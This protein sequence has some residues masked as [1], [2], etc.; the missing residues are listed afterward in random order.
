MKEMYRTILYRPRAVVTA[1]TMLYG[2]GNK[3]EEVSKQHEGRAA[4][5]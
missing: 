2:E 3:P 5:P 1:N 4:Q